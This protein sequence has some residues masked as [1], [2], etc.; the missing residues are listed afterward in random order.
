[1]RRWPAVTAMT[2]KTRKTG[3]V[4]CLGLLLLAPCAGQAQERNPFSWPDLAERL[5]VASEQRLRRI[6]REEI[7]QASQQI[8]AGLRTEADDRAQKM[9]NDIM[10]EL[11]A[12]LEKRGQAGTESLNASE[13]GTVPDGSRFVGCVDGKPLYR[14]A[15]GRPLFVSSGPS[16]AGSGASAGRCG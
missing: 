16:G 2:A 14:D 9:K 4:L 15:S 13:A 6:V 5:E 12:A 11:T 1:M 10:Q 7:D 8:D 3:S